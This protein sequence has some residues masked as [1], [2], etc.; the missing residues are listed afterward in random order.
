MGK[1]EF[2]SGLRVVRATDRTI[3]KESELTVLIE[4]AIITTN[5][6]SCFARHRG[7]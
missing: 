1:A 2:V 5:K 3:Y 7:I 6:I 4:H